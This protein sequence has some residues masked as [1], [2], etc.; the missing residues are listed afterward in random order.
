MSL[1]QTS[2]PPPYQVHAVNSFRIEDFTQVGGGGTCP[3]NM[4]APSLFIFY[5]LAIYIAVN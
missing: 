4:R 1:A 2:L 5:K 3:W